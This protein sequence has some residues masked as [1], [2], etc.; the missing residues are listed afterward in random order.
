[1]KKQRDVIVGFSDETG[2][3]LV[4]DPSLRYSVVGVSLAALAAGV[5]GFALSNYIHRVKAE[6]K[7]EPSMGSAGERLLQLLQEDK[8]ID[9]ETIAY[10]RSLRLENI[11][12]SLDSVLLEQTALKDK[13]M[14]VENT[15]AGADLQ[16]LLNANRDLSSKLDSLISSVAQQSN[17][18]DNHVEIGKIREA[19]SSL[20]N[21]LLDVGGSVPNIRNSLDSAHR[22][23]DEL[24]R[25]SLPDHPVEI[26]GGEEEEP[27]LV[28][29]EDLK[30]LK[31][32]I[33]GS[34]N[35][36]TLSKIIEKLQS[37]VTL[38]SADAAAP[39]YDL[40]S[41]EEKA[42]LG[43]LIEQ[44]G[45]GFTTKGITAADVES[46]LQ[47][48]SSGNSFPFTV[49]VLDTDAL[50]DTSELSFNGKALSEVVISRYDGLLNLVGKERQD[51]FS[52]KPTVSSKVKQPSKAKLRVK[53]IVL[54][55]SLDN[56][57]KAKRA[58][59]Y[60]GD[61]LNDN[62][63]AGLA[64]RA[65]AASVLKAFVS[66]K[67]QDLINAINDESTQCSAAGVFYALVLSQYGI[68]QSSGAGSRTSWNEL[69]T[70]VK[71]SALFERMTTDTLTSLLQAKQVNTILYL[72]YH[73]G[74][75]SI[76]C[77][78]VV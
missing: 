78:R 50:T 29:I 27:R 34:L 17:N 9:E 66:A 42:N 23:L 28:N 6:A 13:L 72:L 19:L 20:R 22:K 77:S 21:E 15:L 40:L 59:A 47:G 2:D 65:S 48:M 31:A 5:G 41:D 44:K 75:F 56:A 52:V 46:A 60:P 38:T 24:L 35:D 32:S 49:S 25:P 14:A 43:K 39:W 16:S 37:S 73:S 67:K 55:E 64:V 8:R 45:D 69:K 33:I 36:V 70:A 54:T 18:S 58:G 12:A 51:Y 63:L 74:L 1:M 68:A 62:G 7:D 53:D 10:I 26:V 71:A 57:I 30:A 61:Q 76:I 11:N 4:L 3:R